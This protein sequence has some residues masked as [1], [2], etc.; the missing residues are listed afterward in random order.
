MQFI[1]PSAHS[2]QL[3]LAA[4][5]ANNCLKKIKRPYIMYMVF[6]YRGILW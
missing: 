5:V 4:M 1:L 3:L 6:F 2:W